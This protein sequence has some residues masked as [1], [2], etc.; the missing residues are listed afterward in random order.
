MTKHLTLDD[1]K[2]VCAVD[3]D[4]EVCLVSQELTQGLETLKGYTKSVTIYGSARFSEDN[5]YYIKARELGYRIAKE[6]GHAVITGGGPGI[7]EAANRG[8]KEGGG[9]SV[10]FTISLPFEQKTNE[11]VTDEIPFSFF[12]IRKTILSHG[13]EVF[14]F[15]PGGYGTMDELF[16]RLTLIQTKKIPQIPIF[17]IGTEFW[18]PLIEVVKM[19]LLEKYATINA[20]DLNIF[21]LTDDIGLVVEAAKNTPERT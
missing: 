15:F 14:V 16:E 4:S 19:Q 1:I 8:A 20:E 11:Y 6:L 2:K 7:M 3:G 9:P 17:L 12:S 5:P 21:T 10:G 13:A 18:T